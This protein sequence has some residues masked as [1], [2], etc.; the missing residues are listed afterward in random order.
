MFF[1][2]D[3]KNLNLPPIGTAVREEQDLKESV[4]VSQFSVYELAGAPLFKED[5]EQESGERSW[6]NHSP[7]SQPQ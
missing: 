1:A 6:R 5:V 2:A 4:Q 3:E 7:R